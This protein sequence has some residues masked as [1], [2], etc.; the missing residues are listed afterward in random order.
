[1]IEFNNTSTIA[2]YKIFK[3]EYKKAISAKQQNIEAL[4]ISS[5][6]DDLKEVNAR[7]VNLKMI[8]QEEFIFF[9]NY[10]SPKS[11][12]FADHSQISA[13]IYWNKT[14]VQIRMK[15]HIK[16]TSKKFNNIY[17]KKR[18]KRKNALAISSKQSYK[19]ESYEA[20]EKNFT[21]ALRNSNLEKCPD[22]WGGY[23]LKPYYFE[24][25]SG[26]EVRINKRE[27]FE[28]TDGIWKHSFLQP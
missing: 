2:P 16:K 11:A 17:F 4:C 27:V 12:E 8:N 7:F 14:N 22:Y 5:Y 19:I 15:A 3:Q 18:N 20:I 13:T 24:F 1:M 26:H 21:H 9:S 6:S 10:N 23:S 28:K 25:W